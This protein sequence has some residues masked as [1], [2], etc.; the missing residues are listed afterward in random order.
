MAKASP[1]QSKVAVI[2]GGE[3]GIGLALANAFAAKAMRW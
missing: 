3:R 1:K 2:T